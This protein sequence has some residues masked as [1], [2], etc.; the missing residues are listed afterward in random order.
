MTRKMDENKDKD[1][2][3]EKTQTQTKMRK[4]TKTEK[5]EKKWEFGRR[6][7]KILTRQA[8]LAVTCGGLDG[9]HVGKRECL[10]ACVKALPHLHFHSVC[11]VYVSTLLHINSPDIDIDLSDSD[12]FTM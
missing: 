3:E 10:C 4:K 8:V 7:C 11:V 9:I 1:M 5:T 2:D 12:F 6:S